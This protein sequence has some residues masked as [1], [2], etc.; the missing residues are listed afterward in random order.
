MSNL[1]TVQ[2]P[3]LFAIIYVHAIDTSQSISVDRTALTDPL[4][5]SAPIYR[6]SK[7]S[8][9]S[10]PV[11]GTTDEKR[12]FQNLPIPSRKLGDPAML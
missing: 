9:I 3:Y 12:G 10:N 4:F 1:C 11:D 2:V 5:D 7:R 8:R 6:P